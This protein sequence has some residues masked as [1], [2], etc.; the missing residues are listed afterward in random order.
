MCGRV[1]TDL[2]VMYEHKNQEIYFSKIEREDVEKKT[3][4]TIIKG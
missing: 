2:L 3:F 4:L 1:T